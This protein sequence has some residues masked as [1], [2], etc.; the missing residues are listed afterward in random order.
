LKIKIYLYK[1]SKFVKKKKNFKNRNRNYYFILYI[2]KYRF[3]FKKKINNYIVFISFSFINIT[4]VYYIID[5]FDLYIDKKNNNNKIKI[6]ILM[7]NIYIYMYISFLFYI[8]ETLFK[9][10]KYIMKE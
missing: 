8:K 7:K 3:F 9:L 5:L 1:I 6:I 4:H 2:S 10:N